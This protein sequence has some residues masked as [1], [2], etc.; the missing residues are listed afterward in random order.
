MR[1]FSFIGTSLVVLAFIIGMVWLGLDLIGRSFVPNGKASDEIE[2][3]SGET[4]I[5]RDQYGV[6]YI[7]AASEED[8]YAALGYAHAQDRLWQMDVV[9]RAGEGRLSEI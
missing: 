9:R 8:A 2:G 4:T 6:P 5:T 1:R 7:T 3:L